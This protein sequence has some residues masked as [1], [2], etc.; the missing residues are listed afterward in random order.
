MYDAIGRKI[1]SLE[2]QN[3]M[4]I[5]TTTYKQKGVQVIRIYNAECQKVIKL[6]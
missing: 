4:N 1:E 6:P 5:N 3:S 2:T